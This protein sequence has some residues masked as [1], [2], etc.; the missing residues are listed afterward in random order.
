MVDEEKLVH[1][2]YFALLREQRGVANESV[3]TR[4]QTARQLF[5]ELC[6]RHRFSLGHD[7]LNVA[8]N[9][10]FADWETRLNNEDTVVF[11]P[12]VAGG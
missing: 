8:V 10:E 7:R 9:E 5:N 12:P 6:Q 11:I 4:S 2:K 3:Q 1:I